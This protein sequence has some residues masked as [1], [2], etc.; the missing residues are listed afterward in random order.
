MKSRQTE[1]FAAVF[2]VDEL[3]SMGKRI[4]I[5]AQLQIPESTATSKL[6]GF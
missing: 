2:F 3:V 1:W 5:A 4:E 6:H